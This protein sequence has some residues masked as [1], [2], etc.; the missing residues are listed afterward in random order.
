MYEVY[1]LKSINFQRHYI[2][3]TGNLDKRLRSHNAGKVRSTKAYRQWQLIYKEF[4]TDKTSARK[5]EIEIKSYKSGEAFKKLIRLPFI[6][7]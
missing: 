4:M 3:Y 5:R 6:K 1:I 2:G 7:K